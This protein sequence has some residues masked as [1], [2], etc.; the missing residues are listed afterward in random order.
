M[1]SN[2][3]IILIGIARFIF[4][5]L[6]C[7]VAHTFMLRRFLFPLKPMG[8]GGGCSLFYL[9]LSKDF[10]QKLSSKYQ[11]PVFLRSNIRHITSGQQNYWLSLEKCHFRDTGKS[12]CFRS[13]K[14]VASIRK[15]KQV[16]PNSGKKL[17]PVVAKSILRHKYAA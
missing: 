11:G 7:F 1:F 9:L 6:A 3:R 13:G 16:R 10:R 12:L 2:S 5:C 4:A 15:N 8:E 17:L 14:T